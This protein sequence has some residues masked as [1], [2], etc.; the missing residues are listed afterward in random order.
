MFFGFADDPVKISIKIQKNSKYFS[1]IQNSIL[2]SLILLRDNKALL[3][4]ERLVVISS[5]DNQI[6]QCCVSYILAIAYN[7]LS[8]F[9]ESNQ[10]FLSA[11]RI[12]STI[13]H[14]ILFTI[15]ANQ[16]VCAYN[17][18]DINLCRKIY[19]EL[20]NLTPMYNQSELTL[21][22][23]EF[24]IS[25]LEDN[26]EKSTQIL[27]KIEENIGSFQPAQLASHLLDEFVFY[28][29]SG[30]VEKAE[31]SYKS[32]K[33]VRKFML[34]VNYNFIKS[35]FEFITNEKT[36]Y[37]DQTLYVDYPQLHSQIN[38][39]A[40]LHS[41]HLDNAKFYWNELSSINPNIYK[42]NF[43][44]KGDRCLFSMALDKVTNL[45]AQS[46]C[47]ANI[48][49]KEDKLLAILKNSNRPVPKEQIYFEIWNME[50]DSKDDFK[51]LAQLVYQVRKR[52]N[53]II[54]QIKGSYYI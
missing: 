36:I 46:Y 13:N 27:A 38:C 48:E 50:P 15:T 24:K 2:N 47:L 40:F 53:I 42:E 23:A 16:F 30:M 22:R 10:Q 49:N 41:G 31:R 51:K 25:L 7:N 43:S 9:K 45:K 19:D 33:K 32:M 35:M 14:P 52:Y 44:Y 37:V 8:L 39:I 54:K 26:I 6:N 34:S 4:I 29:K 3:V 17:L 21:M 1:R 11:K 20:V 28:I 12:A 5:F 18:Q